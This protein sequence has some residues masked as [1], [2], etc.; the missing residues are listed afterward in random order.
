MFWNIIK[1]LPE[2]SKANHKISHRDRARPDS[3]TRTS[4]IKDVVIIP[5]QLMDARSYFYTKSIPS[6]RFQNFPES[7]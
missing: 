1:I 4:A 2:S 6:A 3:Q 5:G 7:T